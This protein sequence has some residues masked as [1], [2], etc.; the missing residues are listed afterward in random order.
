MDI[1]CTIHRLHPALRDDIGDLVTHRPL[2]GPALPNLG[3]FLFL[4]HHGPQVYGAPNR[5]C[6]SGRIPIA[7]SRR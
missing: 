3:A 4:N 7:V 1:P 6:R 5:G 2:P